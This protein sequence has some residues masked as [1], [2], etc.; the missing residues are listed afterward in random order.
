MIRH[1]VMWTL[2]AADPAQRDDDAAQI[3]TALQGLVGVV[4]SVRSLVVT[5]NVEAVEGN[6][7]LVLEAVFD[8]RA[9]LDAYLVHPAHLDAVAIVRAR[10]N[11][12]AAI[13]I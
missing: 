11:G 1:I 12:R 6:S 10:V 9:G 7:D 4:P 5:R 8:D 2:A 3:A 13:D